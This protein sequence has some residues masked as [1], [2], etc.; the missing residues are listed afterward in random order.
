MLTQKRLLH[1]QSSDALLNYS[2]YKNGIFQTQP[3]V[4]LF[5]YR[6]EDETKKLST[7]GTLLKFR[8]LQAQHYY[9][10]RS[11]VVIWVHRFPINDNGFLR[12]VKGIFV[13]RDRPFFPVKCEMAN[14]FL[15]NRDFHS[16]RE[17]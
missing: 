13:T 17:A 12:M 4:F 9:K 15:V 6:L 5:S 1:L 7:T 8:K 10:K 3:E 14:F 16:N 11:A 2:F